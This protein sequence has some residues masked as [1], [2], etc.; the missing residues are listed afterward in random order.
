MT[1]QMSKA[2]RV[3]AALKGRAVDRRPVSAWWHDYKREW[4]AADLA[5][6]TLEYYRK[7]GWDYIKVVVV[8][9]SRHWPPIDRPPFEGGR[10]AL[11]FRHLA[12]HSDVSLQESGVS[13]ENTA[14]TWHLV[15]PTSVPLDL[16]IFGDCGRIGPRLLK[17]CRIQSSPPHPHQPPERTPFRDHLL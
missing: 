6:A 13:C 1:G 15:P 3:T 17:I 7:Y 11:R 10:H 12:R 8:P 5:E 2:E 16:L 14:R 9:P 4:S